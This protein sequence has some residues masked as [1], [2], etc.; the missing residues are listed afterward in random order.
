MLLP[1]RIKGG[2]SV[3]DADVVDQLGK[4]RVAPG[5]F[6]KCVCL[7]AVHKTGYNGGDAIEILC[8]K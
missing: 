2:G 8:K 6:N 7:R 1:V 4:D 5:F 3:R